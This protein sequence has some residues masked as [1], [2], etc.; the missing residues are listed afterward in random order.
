MVSKITPL[1]GSHFLCGIPATVYKYQ[2][3]T[4]LY[5]GDIYCLSSAGSEIT[6]GKFSQ[7]LEQ[8]TLGVGAV[9]VGQL[10]HEALINA[11]PIIIS[12]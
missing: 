1:P 7:L 6:V 4:S 2:V 12:P 8:L 9:T 5:A 10:L 3:Q 11:T